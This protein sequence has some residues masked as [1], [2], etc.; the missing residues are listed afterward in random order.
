MK[1]VLKKMLIRTFLKIVFDCLEIEP[2]FWFEA[3]LIIII[4]K[5]HSKLDNNKNRLKLE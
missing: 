3:M 5:V 4:I 2:D 1:K